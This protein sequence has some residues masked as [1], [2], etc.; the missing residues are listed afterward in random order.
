VGSAIA[1]APA[2]APAAPAAE[3]PRA[4]AARRAAELREHGST[5][6]GSDKFYI[7]PRIVPD[8]W[9]YEYRRFTVM[10]AQDPSYQVTLATKGWEAVPASRHPELMPLGYTGNTIERKGMILMERPKEI[11]DEAKS[12]DYRNARDLVRAKEAQISGAPPGTFDRTNKGSPLAKV[13]KSYESIAIP[14]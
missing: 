11:T 10:G 12:R 6:D 2:P 4:R 1:A 5:D 9:T 13:T 14:D 3:D 7:N 8:G